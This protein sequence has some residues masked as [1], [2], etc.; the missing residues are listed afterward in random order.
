MPGSEAGYEVQN[1]RKMGMDLTKCTK[2][3]AEY[4]WPKQKPRQTQE[5]SKVL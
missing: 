5:K 4:S 1:R 2:C 3:T